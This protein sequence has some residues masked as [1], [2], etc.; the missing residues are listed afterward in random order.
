MMDRAEAV[1]ILG[2]FCGKR[3]IK[4]LT[5]E[6]LY[7]KYGISQADVMVLF[8]GSIIAGG[9][10]LAE[11]I[12]HQAAGKY[13]IV[14]GNGHT[15]Q[16]LRNTVHAMYPNIVTEG[17]P[18]AEVFDLYLQENYGLSADYLETE[19]TNC[20]N[21]ITNLLA[22]L[23]KNDIDFESIILCQDATM[24]YRMEAGL[25][26]YVSDKVQII[27][28]AAY[29]VK[30]ISENNV[31]K[32]KTHIPGMWKMERYISLLLGE[33][34]RLRDDENGYGPKGKGYIAHVDI[35]DEVAEAYQL[36]SRYYEVRKADSDYASK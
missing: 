2:S 26:K 6:A 21:N 14:G 31:L 36:L 23:K 4:E 19:S 27:N 18:E 32:Y 25:R 16:T 28:F 5:R 13:I 30:V 35:P 29:Q 9:D 33:I 24:Q 10:V 22:L 11:A 3:D 15:T 34:P 12:H 1:N 8:G 7:R 17:L 20:G